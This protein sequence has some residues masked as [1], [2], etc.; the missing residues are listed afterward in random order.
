MSLALDLLLIFILV[1][2][3]YKGFKRGFFR[4]VIDLAI[5]FFSAVLAKMCAPLV[6]E[7]FF[8]K[9]IYADLLKRINS[10]IP[11]NVASNPLQNSL[12]IF[13][14]LPKF[15]VDVMS[16]CGIASNDL[17]NILSGGSNKSER[18][19]ELLKPG[20]INFLQGIAFIIL[21][22]VILIVLKSIFR[23]LYRLPKLPF[24][25]SIDSFLGL[26]IGFLKFVVFIFIFVVVLKLLLISL[27]KDVFGQNINKAIEDSYIFKQVYNVNIFDSFRK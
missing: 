20:I 23:F 14:A 26:S 8:D 16:F 25:G 4:S 12:D 9:F 1:Y 3:L 6:A 15:V 19:L 24:I 13:N 17:L 11:N 18:I 7:F 21:S 5:M 2:F 10:I 27:P 22:G